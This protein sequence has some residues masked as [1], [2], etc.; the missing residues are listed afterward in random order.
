M[1]IVSVEVYSWLNLVNKVPYLSYLGIVY[2]VER[3]NP[4]YR[5][6]TENS[7]YELISYHRVTQVQYN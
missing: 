5:Q 7:I 6:A 4:I 2:K 3:Y 1:T